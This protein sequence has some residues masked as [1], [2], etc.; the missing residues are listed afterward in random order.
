[1]VGYNGGSVSNLVKNFNKAGSMYV[2]DTAARAT[3][4]ANA[5]AT[6]RVS[7]EFGEQAPSTVILTVEAEDIN[8]HRRPGHT[9]SLDECEGWLRAG[10]YRITAARIRFSSYWNTVYYGMRPNDIVN[11]LVANGVAVEVI[12]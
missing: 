11:M 6:E 8:F 10:Q 2:T 1:M 3:R 4:Y 9:A 12:E 7:L 5:Q